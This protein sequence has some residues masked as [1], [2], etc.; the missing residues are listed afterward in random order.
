MSKSKILFQLSG[1]I[2]CYKSA[3]IISKL[4]QNGFEVQTVCTKS[5]MEFIGPA[6]LEGL[7]GKKVFSDLFEPGQMMDHIKLAQWADLA[8]LCP[9]TAQSIAG[10]ALGLA[11]DCVSTIFLAYDF[12]KPY[13]VAPAMN[14]AMFKHPATQAHLAKL[15]TWGVTILPT[16]DGHQACGDTGPGRLL[17]PD[18]IYDAITTASWKVSGRLI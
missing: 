15:E 9:A 7:S 14:Q 3:A 17:D 13:L 1:S 11:Q 2:A 5:A 4:V 18:K 16:N 6:T 12:N 10:L 8:I